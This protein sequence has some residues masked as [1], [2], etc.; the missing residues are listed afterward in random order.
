MRTMKAR[1]AGY[2]LWVGR[3]GVGTARSLASARR[4]ARAAARQEVGWYGTVR[5]FVRDASG[6]VLADGVEVA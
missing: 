2:T 5:W 1:E 6:R 3:M 4:R